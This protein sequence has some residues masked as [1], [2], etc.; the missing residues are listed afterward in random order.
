MIIE[1]PKEAIVVLREMGN[2]KQS[3]FG[4][5]RENISPGTPSAMSTPPG[6]DAFS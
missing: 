2:G 6:C 1:F 4:G 5:Q 3:S